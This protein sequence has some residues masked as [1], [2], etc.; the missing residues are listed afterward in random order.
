[1]LGPR[2]CIFR[3][4]DPTAGRDYSAIHLIDDRLGL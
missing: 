2:Q 4:V 3:K 1:M